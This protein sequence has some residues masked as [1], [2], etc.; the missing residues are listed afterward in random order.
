M[1]LNFKSETEFKKWLAQNNNVKDI[2]PKSVNERL[3]TERVN[4]E[5]IN[6]DSNKEKETKIVLVNT[7]QYPIERI[8]LVVVLGLLLGFLLL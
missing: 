6:T 8:V 3:R 2:S 4:T 5:R 1:S 7:Y